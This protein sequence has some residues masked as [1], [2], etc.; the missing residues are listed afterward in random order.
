MH[1]YGV[2]EE[3]LRLVLREMNAAGASRATKVS[4][5]LGDIS[6]IVEESVRFYW[7]FVSRDT[8]A[9]GA[10]LDFARVAPQA[11]CGACGLVYAPESRDQRCP[12]CG[13]ALARLLRGDEFRVES[14]DVD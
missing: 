9:E 4:L 14:I 8:P 12:G 5:I 1:E 10:L 11:R 2:T 13:E 6:G 7:D 3:M